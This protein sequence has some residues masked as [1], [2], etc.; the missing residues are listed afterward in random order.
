MSELTPQQHRAVSALL[1]TKSVAEA[2]AIV[3][4]HERTLFRWLSEPGFRAALSASEGEMIDAATRR[5]LLLQAGAIEAFEKV[6]SDPEAGHAMRIKAASEV[7]NMLLKLRE[8]RNLELRIN[9]L[10]AF[11]Q[12]QQGVS[13]ESKL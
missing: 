3:H 1:S 8:L 12:I 7:L 13:N 5:L 10:E 4:T 6:L 9:R 2:A 11:Q